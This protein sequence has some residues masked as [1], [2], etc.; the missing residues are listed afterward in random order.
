[1]VSVNTGYQF[2]PNDEEQ[3]KGN[4]QVLGGMIGS[5]PKTVQTESA[6]APAEAAG[7]KPSEKYKIEGGSSVAQKQF[8]ANK[9]VDS[10]YLAGAKVNSLK[11]GISAQQDKANQAY[12]AF[13][14]NNTFSTSL[15]DNEV[16]GLI[17][18]DQNASKE[19]DTIKTANNSKFADGANL[20]G[21]GS[22]IQ[23]LTQDVYGL[24]NPNASRG[25][26]SLDAALLRNSGQVGKIRGE[27][28]TGLASAQS[29]IDAQRAEANSLVQQSEATRQAELGRVFGILGQKQKDID[30]QAATV[31][32]DFNTAQSNAAVQAALA[33]L[34]GERDVE[35]GKWEGALANYSKLKAE[36]TAPVRMDPYITEAQDKINQLKTQDLNALIKGVSGGSS[37]GRYDQAA[38]DRFNKISALLGAGDI[39]QVSGNQEFNV[40]VDS[41]LGRF[42]APKD[43]KAIPAELSNQGP[44]TLDRMSTV[45]KEQAN[46]GFFNPVVNPVGYTV[47]QGIFQK[48]RQANANTSKV[49]SNPATSTPGGISG[50]QGVIG[51]KPAEKKENAFD[52]IM[53]RL[54]L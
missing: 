30:A 35:V 49:T 32:A 29:G 11:Q 33:K 17:K 5:A 9:N 3:K 38:A 7:A 45:A 2:D 26:R 34:A 1:M 54:G 22:E 52:K 16:E 41:N 6:A 18:G 31:G 48:I 36:D 19:F 8:D 4:F 37:A 25:G 47:K 21:Y 42:G 43:L 39:R 51:P 28:E 20:G 27:L 44:T 40:Q 53:K 50:N 13:K 23:N 15:D 10:Q 14:S 46:K 12:S 24:T